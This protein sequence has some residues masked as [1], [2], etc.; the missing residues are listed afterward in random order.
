MFLRE[1]WKSFENAVEHASNAEKVRAVLALTLVGVL[2]ALQFAPSGDKALTTAAETLA[3]SVVAF[4]FGLHTGTGTRRG[5]RTE[6]AAEQ[7]VPTLLWTALLLLAAAQRAA[8]QGGAAADEET[9]SD[10]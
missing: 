8:P 1:R 7:P 9:G 3:I 4:Y 10:A 5:L 6:P 2:I